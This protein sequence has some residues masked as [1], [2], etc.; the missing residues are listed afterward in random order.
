MS[1]SLAQRYYFFNFEAKTNGFDVGAGYRLL[2]LEDEFPEEFEAEV[3]PGV[4]APWIKAD[5][6]SFKNPREFFAQHRDEV[7]RFRRAE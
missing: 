7:F 6:A 1:A 2:W 4:W 3:Q 5:V